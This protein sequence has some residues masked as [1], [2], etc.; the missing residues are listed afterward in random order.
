MKPQIAAASF[1][2]LPCE[3]RSLRRST[4]LI[5]DQGLHSRHFLGGQ[6]LERG[7]VLDE[8]RIGKEDGPILACVLALW[9]RGPEEEPPEPE[10]EQ[11]QGFEPEKGWS[12][13]EEGQG[14]GEGGDEGG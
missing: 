3:E 5:A 12:P 6:G 14:E 13:D 4:E 9:P 8:T 7:A 1:L 10:P 2:C 11:P